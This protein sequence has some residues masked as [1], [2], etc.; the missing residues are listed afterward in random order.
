MEGKSRQTTKT[1]HSRVRKDKID[2]Y[3]TQITTHTYY[4]LHTHTHTR[5]RTHRHMPAHLPV[6]AVAH[7][8]NGACELVELVELGA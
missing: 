5:A 1:K 7:I 4:T 8:M 6:A 3:T 2:Q